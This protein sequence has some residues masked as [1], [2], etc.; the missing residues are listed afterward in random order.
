MFHMAQFIFVSD[1]VT[2]KDAAEFW[3]KRRRAACLNEIKE[4][5]GCKLLA[6]IVAT[7]RTTNCSEHAGVF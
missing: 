1:I 4:H 3:R 7:P 6:I 2:F 5:T